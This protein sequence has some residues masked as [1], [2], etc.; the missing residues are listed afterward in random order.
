MNEEKRKQYNEKAGLRM[1]KYRQKS[2][3]EKR[4]RRNNN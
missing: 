3:R 2:K 1:Q 4:S